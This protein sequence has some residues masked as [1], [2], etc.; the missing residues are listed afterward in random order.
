MLRRRPD[1]AEVEIDVYGVGHA[2]ERLS[3]WS[4]RRGAAPDEADLRRMA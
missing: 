2:D 4:R 1:I 3:T